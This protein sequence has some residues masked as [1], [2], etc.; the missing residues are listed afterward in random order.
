MEHPFLSATAHELAAL[1]IATLRYQSPYM[2]R[3]SRRPALPPVCHATVRAAVATAVRPAPALPLFAGGPSFGGRLTSQAQA[4]EPLPGVPGLAF[5][6]F[7]PPPAR[8][9]AAHPPP[10]RVLGPVPEILL[11][12]N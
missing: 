8:R 4:L 3:G 1:G 2:Q 7:P 11:T 12:G 9:P 6:G 10:P 5:L